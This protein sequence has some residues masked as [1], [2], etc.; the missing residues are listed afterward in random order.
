[1]NPK[2][3]KLA[4][5]FLVLILAFVIV[6]AAYLIIPALSD[7]EPVFLQR[8]GELIAAHELKRETIGELTIVQLRLV[9]S[10]GL[11]VDL[12]IRR[13][14]N[15]NAPQPLIILMGGLRT[16]KQAVY[17]SK[18]SPEVTF[19]ALSYPLKGDP[20]AKG[21]DMMLQLPKL[22]QALLDSAPAVLLA[23]DYLQQQSYVDS[24]RVE[25]VGGSL[26]AFLV[27]IPA[28]LDQRFARVWLIHGAGDPRTV[29]EHLLK[30]DIENALLRSLAAKLLEY[31]SVSD[32]LRPERWVNRIENRPVIVVNARDDESLPPSCVASLHQ[33]LGEQAEIIWTEG[34]HVNPG[35]TEVVE[36]LIDLVL[37]RMQ[38]T[39][40][41]S[42]DTSS[43]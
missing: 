27:S 9:S 34:Y 6:V 39:K 25:L 20:S 17:F 32:Y 8:K 31:V 2:A 16:G 40:P 11:E 12:G 7:P 21:L 10:S 24:K 28:A 19:A 42:S 43:N 26:G 14:S 30:D 22:Q 36:G 33:A 38:T 35:R 41:L 29:F 15:S 3:I 13:L 1:M 4:A 23:M 5:L 37:D 18:R